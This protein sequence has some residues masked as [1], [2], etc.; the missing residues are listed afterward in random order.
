[1]R[2]ISLCGTLLG[3]GALPLSGGLVLLR[4]ALAARIP[5]GAAHAGAA[6]QV[7][8]LRPPLP[9]RVATAASGS[10][11]QPVVYLSHGEGNANLPIARSLFAGIRPNHHS[12]W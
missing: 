6:D 1:M 4:L 9:I 7:L 8:G 10:G 5:R 2:G 12:D 3:S 11:C